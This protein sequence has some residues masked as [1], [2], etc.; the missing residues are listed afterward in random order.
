[1]RTAL[2]RAGYTDD[3]YERTVVPVVALAARAVAGVDDDVIE[4]AVTGTGRGATR[5][6]GVL[7]RTQ[8]GNVQAYATG[9]L[10]GVLLLVFG[11][12]VFR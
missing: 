10:L 7:R 1:V 11:S 8:N 9:L 12:V 2:A 5:L 6:G 3:L 4:R